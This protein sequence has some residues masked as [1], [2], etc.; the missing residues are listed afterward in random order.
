MK[1]NLKITLLFIIIF[2][3]CNAQEETS[4][5]IEFTYLAQTRGSYI[6]ITFTKDSLHLNSTEKNKI[7][8]L[9]EKQRENILQEISKINLSEISLLIAPSNKRFSDR[10]L[11]AKFTFKKE[12]EVYT[13]SDFDH[14]NPP[15]KLKSLYSILKKIIKKG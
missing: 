12:N 8:D 10:T 13:S 15:E 2:S 7:I 4:S 11:S 5:S 3:S 14:E 6:N 1:I 9:N